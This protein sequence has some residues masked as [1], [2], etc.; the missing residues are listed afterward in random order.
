MS[1]DRKPATRR[2]VRPAKPSGLRG[3]ARYAVLP[4][5]AAVLAGGIAV[6]SAGGAIAG[7]PPA[8]TSDQSWPVN[9]AAAATGQQVNTA[10]LRGVLTLRSAKPA[11]RL[12]GGNR[13]AGVY[14]APALATGRWVSA[15]QV[16]RNA[17]VPAGAELAVDVR[18]R[19]VTGAWTQWREPD[20]R[21]RLRLPRPVSALQARL[22]LLAST[23]GHSPSISSLTLRQVALPAESAGVAGS[24]ASAASAGTVRSVAPE[25]TVSA[26]ASPTFRVF[27][28]RE[29]LVGGHTANGHVI[30]N[31]DH[32]VALP[33][34]RMLASN[35]GREY[36]VKVCHASQCETAPVWDLGPWNKKDDYWNPASVRQMFTDLPQG[37]PEAQAAYQDGYNGGKDDQGRTLPNPAGIDLADGTFWDGLGMKNNDWVTVTFQP[38]GDTTT[39]VT[40]WMDANVRS[41]PHLSCNPPVSK[42]YANSTYPAVC[43]TT[44]DTITDQGTTNDKWVKLPLTAG[45][46]GYVSGIY[47][48]GDATG[49]VTTK[50]A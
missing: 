20:A 27:A 12:I 23:D 22:S 46:Y 19:D 42:V 37:K 1:S 30:T 14:T 24:A 39:Q 5:L 32:F 17:A 6:T 47:L 4:A 8:P 13:G 44:G 16:D 2:L 21:G 10:A 33:S 11:A 40:A 7:P 28:T 31:R 41:C 50:C 18:G 15:V 34:R 49:G 48:K 35:G 38:T 43:W 3:P 36:Q 9:L 45:G 25:A 26:A 29:G